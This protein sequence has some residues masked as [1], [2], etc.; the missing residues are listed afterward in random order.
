MIKQDRGG[1][2]NHKKSSITFN[3]PVIL[4]FVILCIISLGF[5]FITNGK[6]NILVFSVYRSSFVSPFTY[7]R[8]FGHV[9]GHADL[10]HFLNNIMLILVIGPL[11]EEKYG[12][13][14]I[15]I[16]IV[17]TALITGLVHILLFPN[18]RLLGASGVVFAFILLSS[19]TSMEDGKLPITF[20][21]VAFLYIGQELYSAF[22]LTDNISNL[23][24]I[25]GGIIGAW[26]GYIM[27]RHHI[28]KY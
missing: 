6:S 21:I 5:S 20:I 8:L 3:S 15:L 23:T 9:L 18:I 11:L 25:L 26:L 2:M 24:H 19:F 22:F 10:G 28:A 14:N 27:N 13:I 17:I 1:T 12:S 16:V 7:I 4:S